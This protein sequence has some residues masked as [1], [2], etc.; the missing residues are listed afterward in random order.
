MMLPNDCST[1]KFPRQ[2][3]IKDMKYAAKRAYGFWNHSSTNGKSDY[4]DRK[5]VGYY[6]IRFRS[7]EKFGNV[8]IVPMLDE[9]GYLWN[10]QILNSDGTKIMAK[11][12]RTD[13]LFHK[14][15]EPKDG[16]SIGIAEGYVTAATC[17][18]LSGMP[19][20]CAFSSENL[21]AVTKIVIFSL[22]G[23]SY[24]LVC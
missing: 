2:I 9:T 18:E 24:F 21:V 23:V 12:A 15:M 6:G 11:D 10:Y 17:M 19:T 13:G 16:E 7:D 14:L 5:G 22:S 4:L 1:L 3:L 8:A 20:I